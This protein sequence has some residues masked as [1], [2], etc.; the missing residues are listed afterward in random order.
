MTCFARRLAD[1]ERLLGMQ[2]FS[3]SAHMLESLAAAGFD[4]AMIDTEHTEIS[5][6]EA[7]GLVRAAQSFGMAAL[8]RVHEP[9]PP[10]ISKALDA[11]AD[12]VMVPRVITPDDMQAALDAAF[13]PPRGKRGM[14][15]DT[16]AARYGMDGWLA[17]A[18][19]A[20]RDLAVVPLI[21]DVAALAHIDEICAADG[22]HGVCFGPG[23]FGVSIGAAEEGFSPRIQAETQRALARVAEACRRHGIGLMTTPLFDLLEPA[24]AMRQMAA[25]DVTAVL[26]SIDTYLFRALADGI[27]GAFRAG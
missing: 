10:N 2:C 27:A 4:Y 6:V 23:D 7:I 12:G 9:Y 21:E 18:R 15:P 20:H 19:G 16:R 17:H 11:G 8:V 22:V 13:F 25:D 5:I 26:Y 24:A 1:R 3:A 14:C